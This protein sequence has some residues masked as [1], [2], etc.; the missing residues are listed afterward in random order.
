M[1]AFYDFPVSNRGFETGSM[2]GWKLDVNTPLVMTGTPNSGTYHTDGGDF[3]WGAF[4]QDMTLPLHVSSLVRQGVCTVNM[5]MYQNDF[6]GDNDGQRLG[7]QVFNGSGEVVQFHKKEFTFAFN[8]TWTQQTFDEPLHPDAKHLRMYWDGERITGTELSAYSDDWEIAINSTALFRYDIGLLNVAGGNGTTNWTVTSGSL[9][10]GNA[11]VQSYDIRNPSSTYFYSA[12]TSAFVAEQTVTVADSFGLGTAIDTGSLTFHCRYAQASWAAGNDEARMYIEYYDISDVITGSVH[13]VSTVCLKEWQ[14]R[15]ISD[16]MPANTRKV[17]FVMEGTRLSGTTCDGYITAIQGYLEVNSNFIDGVQAPTFLVDAVEGSVRAFPHQ[18][19]RAYPDT[20]QRAYPAIK[21]ISG[22][23]ATDI[24][25]T[26]YSNVVFHAHFDGSDAATAAP[27]L[28]NSNH[29]MTFVNQAQLDTAQKVFGTASLLLDGTGD[30]VTVPDSDDW[31][32]DGEFT[33]ELRCRWT[34]DGSADQTLIGQWNTASNLRSWAINRDGVNNQIEFWTSPDGSTG[35]VTLFETFD[36]TLDTW[37]EIAVDYDGSVLR[38]YVDGIVYDAEHIKLDVLALFQSTALMTIGDKNDAS[39][40]FNGHIDEVIITKGF[41]KFRGEY[42]TR[43]VLQ[44]T[45]ENFANVELLMHMEGADAATATGD[46]SSNDAT[47]TFV[48]GAAIDTAQSKFG[49]SSLLIGG[50]G[51]GDWVTLPDNAGYSFGAGD[52]TIDVQ[53]RRNADET[54][55]ILSKYDPFATT[56]EY[57]LYYSGTA[58]T[59][60][61]YYGTGVNS[62]LTFNGSWDLGV[63]VWNHVSMER[64]GNTWRLYANGSVVASHSVSRTLKDSTELLYIGARNHTGQLEHPGWIDEVRITKGV[65][66]Y[67]GNHVVQTEPWP[68]E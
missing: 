37:Y 35:L 67:S 17:K 58:L 50:D 56:A 62:R 65:A 7:L 41:A 10:I 20:G 24:S 40:P 30:R 51:S 39:Q 25:T 43:K 61:S 42:T 1:S 14:E 9:A 18:N 12:N 36:P 47:P 60:L 46:R 48:G 45:D 22:V 55:M 59:W 64:A 4:F 49:G 53:V 52:F 8:G 2:Q 13:H 21:T 57:Y 28:S 31:Y 23:A 66:L 19:S 63:D 27:D 15:D 68:N 29:T 33:I 11:T 26:A 16:V 6:S 38:L 3:V 34:A 32:F 54:G 44:N 5:S